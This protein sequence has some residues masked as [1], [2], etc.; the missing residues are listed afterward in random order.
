MTQAR[1]TSLSQPTPLAQLTT[2][3]E[4][5]KQAHFA[6]LAQLATFTRTASCDLVFLTHYRENYVRLAAARTNSSPAMKNV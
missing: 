5:T 6:I 1:L 2:L 4:L 3:A